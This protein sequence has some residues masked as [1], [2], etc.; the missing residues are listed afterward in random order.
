LTAQPK[1]GN[2][3]RDALRKTAEVVI[4]ACIDALRSGSNFE[5]KQSPVLEVTERDG[6][7]WIGAM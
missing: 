3:A 1:V 4:S 5:L 7:L 2:G 6:A